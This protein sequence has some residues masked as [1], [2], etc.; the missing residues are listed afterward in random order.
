LAQDIPALWSAATTTAV[1][2]QQLVRLLIERVVVTV[3]GQSEQVKLAITWAGGFISQHAFVRSV[4]S[5]Q[6]L[7]DYPRLCARIDELRDQGKSPAEVARRL[8]AAGFLPPRRATRFSG[9]MVAGLLA[10]RQQK[11]VASRPQQLAK[12]LRKTEWLVGALAR[13]LR[14]PQATLHHWRKAGWLRARKLDITGGLWAIA[15][16]A[17]ERRRLR[18]LRHHQQSRPNQEIPKE[19]TTPTPAN[20]HSGTE[21]NPCRESL[22]PLLCQ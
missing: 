5:Y 16:S 8:N 18:R 4:G 17:Q 13:H 12:A 20:R 21:A 1:D 2:R 7:A 11:A 14:M 15:A 3:Q 9:G 19:L 10:R 22:S 6:Q